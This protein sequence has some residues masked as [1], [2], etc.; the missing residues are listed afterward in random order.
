MRLGVLPNGRA[1]ASCEYAKKISCRPKNI[2]SIHTLR[3]NLP[4][5]ETRSHN[6]PRED[7]RNDDLHEGGKL[8]CQL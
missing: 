8:Q 3:Q 4:A 6:G 7:L 2:D 1:N 5:L